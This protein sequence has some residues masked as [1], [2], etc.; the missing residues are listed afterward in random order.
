[1]SAHLG[2]DY[3]PLKPSDTIKELSEMCFGGEPVDHAAEL[4]EAL[5]SVLD[6]ICSREYDYDDFPSAGKALYK[7]KQSRG[8]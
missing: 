8:E 7:Y 3:K 5:E 1:M 2:E 6:R 4:A